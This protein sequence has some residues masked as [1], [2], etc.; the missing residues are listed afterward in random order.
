MKIDK[1][2]DALDL[3]SSITVQFGTGIPASTKYLSYEQTL[4]AMRALFIQQEVVNRKELDDLKASHALDLGKRKKIQ[5]IPFLTIGS[6]V[7]YK[8][9][10]YIITNRDKRTSQTGNVYYMYQ[11]SKDSQYGNPVVQ[12]KTWI[13][14]NELQPVYADGEKLI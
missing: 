1:I 3:I 5:L 13:Y 4:T 11:I 10:P 7:W 8:G 14:E 2:D 12:S 9:Y 6:L